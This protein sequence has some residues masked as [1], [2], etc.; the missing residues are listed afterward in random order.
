MPMAARASSRRRRVVTE[1]LQAYAFLLPA[2]LI[3]FVFHFLPAF[4]AVYISLFKWDIVQGPFRGLDNYATVLLGA[5]AQEFWLSL[6]TTFTYVLFTVPFEMAIALA[7]AYLLFGRLRGRGVYRAVYF[8]PYITATVAAAVVFTWLFNPT[9][10]LFNSIL[11]GVG[12]GPQKWLDEPTGLFQ[13][14][15]S[16]FGVSVPVWAAGPSLALV[17]VCI[18]TIWHFV[19]FQTVIFLAGLTNISSEYYEAARLDGANEMQIFTKITLPLL[20]PTT[21][22]VATI[23]TIGALKAFNQIYVMTNGGPLDSTR[24]VGYEIFKTFFQ[25]GRIDLGSAMAFI[26]TGIILVFTLVQFR[27]AGRRVHYA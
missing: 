7:I 6:G 21:F 13:L 12:I 25:Q 18:F 24:V 4:G 1:H 8:L 9:Y 5:R 19:G 23:A 15:G 20:S 27:L 16:A 26:L 22:F 10:G 17:G 14:V 2:A 3:L 11:E